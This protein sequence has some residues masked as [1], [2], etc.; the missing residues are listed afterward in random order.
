MARKTGSL[1]QK[2]GRK[3]GGQPG[4]QGHTLQMQAIPDKTEKMLSDYCSK[5][6]SDI[7]DV[8]AVLKEKRQVIELP[9]LRPVCT[10]YE[11]YERVCPCCSQRQSPGFAP[12]I[13][14]RIQ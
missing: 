8:E 13:H 11:Q 2:T 1:R 5:C 12:H 10:E 3:A 4:H 9:V 14:N 7:S 6:G